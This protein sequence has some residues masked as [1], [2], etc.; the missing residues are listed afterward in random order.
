MKSAG[1][2]RGV[3]ENLKKVVKIYTDHYVIFSSTIFVVFT[4]LCY[5][6]T[7]N[8]YS[9]FGIDF[10]QFGSLSDVYQA[11]LSGGILPFLIFLLFGLC[12]I[13]IHTFR[14]GQ[15]LVDDPDFSPIRWIVSFFLLVSS[16]V[17]VTFLFYLAS[18]K[19]GE[20]KIKEG[21]AARYTIHTEN[22]QIECLPIVAT[23]GDYVVVWDAQLTEARVIPRQSVVRFDLVIEP[24][25]EK[26][27]RVRKGSHPTELQLKELFEKQQHW[28]EKL[29]TKCGMSVDWPTIKP[30]LPS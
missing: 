23:T 28:S 4:G 3:I 26:Y 11:A 19:D 17:M 29:K 2:V 14:G 27:V 9:N 30:N 16:F 8:Y 20:L 18:T 13:V 6:Y 7:T 12:A 24:P 1:L 22:S 21:F 5:L 25:P 10:Y 15:E